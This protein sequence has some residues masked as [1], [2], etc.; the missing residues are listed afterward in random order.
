MPA[1]LDSTVALHWIRGNGQYKQF[2]A[3]RVS[4]IHHHPEI[5]WRH[6]P[7]AENPA[8][9]A[10][11]GGQP[12]SLWW[13]GPGWF[14]DQRKWPRSL[15]TCPTTTSEAEAKV[16]QEVDD[17]EQLLEKHKLQRALRVTAWIARFL[18]NCKR[19]NKLATPCPP[20]SLRSWRREY[21]LSL[22]ENSPVNDKRRNIAGSSRG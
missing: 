12:T 1:W 6:I 9:L 22:H 7:T 16:I 19:D 5:Q 21:L 2:V 3:N 13:N 15:V 11:R 4:K 17:F 20:P 18:R 10:S 8:D 14:A